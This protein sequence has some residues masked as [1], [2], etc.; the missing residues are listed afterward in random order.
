MLPNLESA[1][2]LGP[3]RTRRAAVIAVAA[4]GLLAL[5]LPAAARRSSGG[6]S[7]SSASSHHSTS[8]RSTYAGG[9]K[10]DSH[11]RIARSSEAKHEFEKQSG[12]PHGWPGHVVDHITPLS[13]GGAD[14]PSNMQ[15]QTKEEA[16]AKDKVERGPS[17]TSSRS[18]RRK[19]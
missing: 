7:P 14:S 19:R 17:K 6:H 4:L 3:A 12:H 2:S 11:G 15:W 8:H 18:H 5:A 1:V 9:L 16:K 13:R 10:R